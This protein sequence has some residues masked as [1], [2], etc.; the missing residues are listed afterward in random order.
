MPPFDNKMQLCYCWDLWLLRRK[1]N[2]EKYMRWAEVQMMIMFVGMNLTLSSEWDQTPQW[3]INLDRTKITSKYYTAQLSSATFQKTFYSFL[4]KRSGLYS[5]Y[6]LGLNPS[7][8][9]SQILFK[10]INVCQRKDSVFLD[11]LLFTCW[12]I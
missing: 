9:L 4:E 2:G 5:F 12:F 6:L 7:P 1:K 11:F 8:A 10:L 3:A